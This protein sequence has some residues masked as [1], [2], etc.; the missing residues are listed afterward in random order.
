MIALVVL[1][2]RRPR[3]HGESGKGLCEEIVS[4]AR[5]AGQLAALLIYNQQG[6]D[7]KIPKINCLENRIS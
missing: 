6:L 5:A 2:Q 3:L 1:V 4:K 7:K